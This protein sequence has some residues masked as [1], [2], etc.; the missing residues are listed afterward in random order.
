MSL[1]WIRDSGP[2][3]LVAILFLV[4][5]HTPAQLYGQAPG[6]AANSSAAAIQE[7]QKHISDY[8]K[9]HKQ[10]EGK[11]SP[12]NQTGVS[13]KITDHQ[14]ML[15]DGIIAARKSAKQG[16]IF[17]NKIIAEFQRL[18][19]IAMR[20]P[21]GA[22]IRTSLAHSE[23]VKV[24]VGVNAKYPGTLPLQSSPPTLLLHLPKLPPELDYR[25]V[26]NALVLRDVTANLVIDF[27]PGA[28][29]SDRG[30]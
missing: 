19:G 3:A 21:H 1:V 28:I 14:Q 6:T 9:L 17:S 2:S 25:I 7:F 26:G 13:K 12:L 27:M 15:A 8:V 23:P 24:E 30:R 5:L 11:L 22:D 16:D 10:V 29:S 4:A 20:G 18:I